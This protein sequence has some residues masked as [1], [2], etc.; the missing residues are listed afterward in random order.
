MAGS[1]ELPHVSD[2]QN[3]NYRQLLSL[4]YHDSKVNVTADIAIYCTSLITSQREGI[5]KGGGGGRCED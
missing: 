4:K 2:E 3:A 5:G 1:K